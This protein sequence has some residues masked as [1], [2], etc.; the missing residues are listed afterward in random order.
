MSNERLIWDKLISAGL[1]PAGAAG[2]LGNLQAESGLNPRNL[3]NS[4]EKKLGMSDEEYTAA[5]DSGAYK[6]FVTDGA[7][8][9]LAQWTNLNRKQL[10]L[11]FARVG[12]FSVGNLDTQL[13][14]LIWE[15]GEKFPAVWDKLRTTA[16]VQEASDCVLLQFER[17]TSIS[18]PDKLQEV[19]DRRARLAQEAYD[20]FAKEA[21]RMKLLKC[22]LTANDCYKAGHTIKPEGVMVHSTG[23]DN[24]MLRRYVQP[25]ATTPGRE[26]LLAQLGVNPNGN[27]WNQTRVWIYTDGSRTVGTRNYSKKLQRV[28]YEP[29]VHGFIGK[30]AD[31]SVAAVQTLPWNHRG[32]HCGSGSKGSANDT[33]ISFEICEDGLTDPAYFQQAYQTAVELT[34]MLCKEY[35]LDPLADG[36]VMCHCEG[37]ERGV[38]S[39]HGDVLHWFPRHGKSMDDFRAD[40]DRAMKMKEEDD[41][42]KYYVTL[43]DVPEWYKPAVQKAV[44][45]GALNGTGGGELNVSEDLCRTLTVLD[46]LGVLG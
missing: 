18:D 12:A 29:C 38:A 22:L 34:A 35:G 44:D 36:V 3:Q 13:D 7:G 8:Y 5:V 6:D 27:H 41:E 37:F 15:L 11:Y 19:K 31:G 1:T 14:Y 39:N 10:L 45:R 32:W 16:S 33:H 4:Y 26:E 20:K 21:G 40:V 28:L 23:A 43:K 2:L 46:R 24:P 42:M 30:L 9:G 17:P 25:V